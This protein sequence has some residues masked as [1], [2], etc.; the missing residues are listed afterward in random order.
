VTDAS[1]RPGF[2]VSVTPLGLSRAVWCRRGQKVT[3]TQAHPS[4]DEMWGDDLTLDGEI[5]QRRDE[6]LAHT[7]RA[8][9]KSQRNH[10]FQRGE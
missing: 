2:S 4:I 10:A 9:K 3:R 5:G 8:T 7:A 6:P 1:A